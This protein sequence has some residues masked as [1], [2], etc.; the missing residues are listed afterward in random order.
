MRVWLCPGSV[1]QPK[2]LGQDFRGCQVSV[3][4][5]A[6]VEVPRGSC[7]VHFHGLHEVSGE[8]EH[9]QVV[10]DLLH[11]LTRASE[12]EVERGVVYGEQRFC[13][14]RNKTI[15]IISCYKILLSSTTICKAMTVVVVTVETLKN[16]HFRTSL[17]VPGR[18]IVLSQRSKMYNRE[19]NLSGCEWRPRSGFHRTT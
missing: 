16:G 9:L 19:L 15:L 6:T 7:I 5:V 11:L 3:N 4:P 13:L 2:R 17:F 18:E 1:D 8:P 14:R 12:G 10:A